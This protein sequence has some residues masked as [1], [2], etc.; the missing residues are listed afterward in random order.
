VF[1]DV[2]TT[3]QIPRI[4][5]VF[6][7]VEILDVGDPRKGR[8]LHVPA[9]VAR[10][11]TD[12]AIAAFLAEEVQEVSLA[13]AQFHYILTAD[14][15]GVDQPPG[16]TPRVVLKHWG[17][18]KR[19]VIS[20]GVLQPAG[21]ERAVPDQTAPRTESKVQIAGAAGASL[22][23]RRPLDADR[24]RHRSQFEKKFAL[25][26]LANWTGI[27]HSRRR[28]KSEAESPILTEHAKN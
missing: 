1:E 20:V 11:K 28:F 19:V 15:V 18:V 17:E 7:S 3:D 16:K 12:P 26:A 22:L 10:I 21:I 25:S 13:A 27:G 14:V 24:N 9:L 2:T 8:T 5:G 6:L 23:S 4:P